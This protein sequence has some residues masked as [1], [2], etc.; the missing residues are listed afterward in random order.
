MRGRV[1]II[2]AAAI[3]LVVCLL[4]YMF[5]IRPRKA[6]V[7]KVNDEIVAAEAQTQSLQLEVDRLQTLKDNAP[8]LNALLEEI[9]GYVPKEDELPNFIFQVEEAADAAGVSFVKITPE[10]PK[11]PATATTL[12]EIRI[13]IDATGGFF[14]LQD[15]VRRLYSLDRALRVDTLSLL[16]DGGAAAE[17]ETGTETADTGATEGDLTLSIAARIFFELPA[18]APVGT[19]PPAGTPPADGTAPAPGETVPPAAPEATET[20]APETPA[21][22]P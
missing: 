18:N 6:E 22:A 14:S 2:G 4:F 20:T 7:S 3:A 1:K 10:L 13:T 9:R 17:G 5:F 8:E 21:P 12:A 15:F 19:T 11:P 16:S